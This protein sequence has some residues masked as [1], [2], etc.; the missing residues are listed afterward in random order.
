V[1]PR[2]GIDLE[3]G[4]HLSRTLPDLDLLDVAYGAV[5]GG[6][7]IIMLPVIAVVAATAYTPAM[8]KRPGLP[9][10]ALKA[11][12]TDVDRVPALGNDPDRIVVTGENNQ[13][14]A[15]AGYAAEQTARVVRSGQEV[16]ILCE[17]EA[18]PLKELARAKAHWAY[19]PT[20]RAYQAQTAEECQME[21]ARLQSAAVAANRLHLRVALFGPTGRYLPA[22][23]SQVLHVE[24]IYPV[25]DL[26]SLALRLGWEKAV[27]EYQL[28][29]R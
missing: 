10:L 27:S 19:L 4:I 11:E 5:H 2:V 29:L 3:P 28:W 1:S 14:V 7:Q 22:A 17:P 21:I 15:D 6:A 8:F 26:W 20:M 13:S 18:A 24:E 9:L 23:L 16:G 25:P 12:I